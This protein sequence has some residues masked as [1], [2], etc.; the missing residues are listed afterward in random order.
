MINRNAVAA[1][2]AVVFF[3]T[4]PGICD[5]LEEDWND[6]LHYTVIGRLDLAEGFAQKIVQEE[7][8]PLELLAL[9][10]SNPRGYSTLLRI[11]DSNTPLREF[12][13]KM[14]DIIE[15]GRY[16]RRTEAG[17]IT[18]EIKRL[19]GTTRGRIAAM[20][21]LKNSGEY[22]IVYMLDAMADPERQEELP[23]IV[24]ALGQMGKAAIRPLVAALQTD[25]VA[26]KAEIIRALGK[27]GYPQAAAYLKYIVENSESEQ[28]RQLARQS[29]EQ[30]DPAG[31]K[32][33]AAELFFSLG[34][35][36][37]NHAESLAPAADYEFAN[38][39]FWDMAGRRIVRQEV[40]KRYFNEL[41]AMRA[42]EWAL[43]AD[44]NIGKAI[45]LWLAAFLK[46]ESTG[47]K[48]PEYFGTGHAEALTYATTAG[49]E[50]LH[51]ALSRAIKD[52][53]AYI[54][55]RIV[56]ALGTTAGEKSLLYGV[57]MEQPLVQAL[58]FGDR[59]VRYSA[60][61][62]IGSACPK[63]PFDHSGLVIETLVESI[64]A[65]PGEDWDKALADSYAD[66]SIKVM[67]QLAQRQNKVIDLSKAEPALI[68]ATRDSRKSIQTLAGRVLAWLHC[69]K[70]QQAI[71]EMALDED[72]DI[73][74]RISAFDSLAQ[75]A[76]IN[77]SL[78]DDKILDA[79]YSLISSNTANPELRSHAA[80][81]YGALNLP[82]R[83]VKNLILDQAKN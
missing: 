3:T 4:I 52:N 20:E 2:I 69:P 43:K 62:A 64:E 38:I 68:K 22:A 36:Y 39:W 45:S 75:S 49:V 32:L 59:A 60:A 55:L 50:Y 18:E 54:A 6:F 58:S 27:I 78:L 56:E 61:I 19:S 7:P 83:K 67:L 46:A 53:N 70:A 41:M 21:R 28:L 42:C 11:H 40:D 44:M 74:I 29:I 30:I 76:K 72:N 71:A 35:S 66:R 57:G 31:T 26:I 13:G 17:I 81:A 5:T 47:L 12:A 14:L 34:E 33:P 25:N 8:D 65:K 10:E 9:S 16:L 82:S 51:Q 80:A 1:I 37:Y 48:M 63:E 15:Q 23:N 24:W 79:I 73:N 77:G